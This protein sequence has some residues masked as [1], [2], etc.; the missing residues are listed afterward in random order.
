[1]E[2]IQLVY[3]LPNE[4]VTAIMMLYKSEKEMICLP[5]DNTNF[6]QTYT[7]MCI[8]IYIYILPNY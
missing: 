5:S 1:M 4:T 2:Q 3:G 8:Y 7:H 6:L